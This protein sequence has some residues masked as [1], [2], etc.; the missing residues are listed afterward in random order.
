MFKI[1][2]TSVTAVADEDKKH[3]RASALV[4]GNERPPRLT[5]SVACLNPTP[6]R[7]RENNSE[8]DFETELNSSTKNR[9]LAGYVFVYVFSCIY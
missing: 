9:V 2:R 8:R 6:V 5:G 1:D 7:S 3:V 4:E